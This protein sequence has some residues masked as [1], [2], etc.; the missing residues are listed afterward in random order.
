[1]LQILPAIG[2]IADYWC[3]LATSCA[4]LNAYSCAINNYYL[5][6]GVS[7]QREE[8]LRSILRLMI[9]SRLTL[10]TLRAYKIQSCLVVN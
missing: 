6:C 8:M 3:T 7:S 9:M 10:S 2:I 1:M 4:N 5:F